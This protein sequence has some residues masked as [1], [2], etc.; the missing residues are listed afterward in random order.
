MMLNTDVELIFDI[1]VHEEHKTQCIP[2]IGTC[3]QKAH[4]MLDNGKERC[5]EAPTMGLVKEYAV[6]SERVIFYVFIF[7]KNDKL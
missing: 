7:S 5:T 6:V 4:T 1:D 2:C 3:N